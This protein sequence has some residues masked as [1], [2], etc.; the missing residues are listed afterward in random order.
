MIVDGQ[1]IGGA[2]Q[3]VG[4]ALCE[5]SRYDG[6]GQPLSST[7]AD[8]TMPGSTHLP[9]LRLDHLVTPS[10]LTE[11]GVKGLGE[12][13]AIPPPAAIANAVNDAL[14]DLGVEVSETPVTPRRVLER[15]SAA[16][17]L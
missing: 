14:G 1:I 5:E 15:I 16:S 4:T 2:L 12:G 9:R 6:D 3:G 10:P 7:F 17:A 13:G 8:Y 11:Y